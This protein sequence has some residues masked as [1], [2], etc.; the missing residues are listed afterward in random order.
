MIL[1]CK[2][3]HDECF[4]GHFSHSPWLSV[5][6]WRVWNGFLTGTKYTVSYH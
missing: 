5:A 6:P 1:K 4:N 3:T 2:N